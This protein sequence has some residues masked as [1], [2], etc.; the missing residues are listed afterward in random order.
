MI[1]NPEMRRMG[2]LQALYAMLSGGSLVLFLGTLV[3]DIAYARTF[4]IQWIN[5]A[6]WLNAGS[7]VVGALALVTALLARGRSSWWPVLAW[8]ATWIAGFFNALM[9]A[10]DAW[11]AMPGALT[12]SWIVLALGCIAT[13]LGLRGR[14]P[15]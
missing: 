9:H 15:T 12:L 2:G 6:A 13:W 10:R 11:A 1:A 7:L 3:S 5:F 14:E 4:E 8:L